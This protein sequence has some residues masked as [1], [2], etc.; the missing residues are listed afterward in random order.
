M[1]TKRILILLMMGF[2]GFVFSQQTRVHSHNDYLQKVPFWGA[3]Y[4][5]ATSI[6]ADVILKDGQLYVAHDEKSLLKERTFDNLYLS[7]IVKAAELGMLTK[8]PLQILIDIKTESKSTLAEVVK[9]I[10]KYPI[11]QNNPSLS[12][13]ISGNRPSPS[14]YK[15]YPAFIMFDHQ[16]LSPLTT[17]EWE[18][19]ALI[20]LSVKTFTKWNGKGAPIAT[21]EKQMND[22]I[23][24][25]K[26]YGKPF[27]FWAIPDAKSSWEYFA[28]AGVNFI[29]TDQPFLCRTYIEGLSRRTYTN[30][31]ISE[32]YHPAFATDGS[33]AP[34]K[35]VILLIG[36]GNGLAQISSSLLANG[37][38]LTLSQLKHIG[39]I[40]TSST[41]N[42][43]T[44]SA[45]GATAMATGKKTRNRYIGVDPEGNVLASIPEILKTK[46]Y[47]TGI[48]TT[49]EIT[50][51]TPSAF[52]AHQPERD[53]AKEIGKEFLKSTL[54]LAVAGG[55]NSFIGQNHFV[56]VRNPSEL[57][58]SKAEQVVMW[59]SEGSVPSVLNGRKSILSESVK[60]GL[61]FLQSK[62]KPFFL[63]VEGAQ[64]DSGGH[65][66]STGTII[67]EGID[68]DQ[69][70]AEAVKFADQNSGTLVII[71]A[72]HETG[73]FSL[74]HGNLK[75][76]VVEGAFETDDHSGIMVPI[77]SYGP[78]A[79]EFIGIYENH[80][81][82]H[83]I[84][85]VLA[86]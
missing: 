52:Y 79:D 59:L 66:N 21:D 42:F 47:N 19:V 50:G 38:N 62:N 5:G 69:A 17:E 11:L 67:T 30:S 6:E 3:L 49:D 73:G 60:A 35:N 56:E 83:K 10:E 7:S 76:N 36:D 2:C 53:M 34:V 65:A 54:N 78:H 63:M 72:D 37:G 32:I 46:G 64:I 22:A 77:F 15:N 41:D 40:K 85:K 43:S 28:R 81:V 20:S 86:K 25:A 13:V 8:S 33:I 70:I 12:F 74:P 16:S 39:L 68:F 57:A 4:A 71:T 84:M 23:S 14:E 58:K 27:R 48:I 18:K 80:E 31:K 26:K 24:T 1:K 45:A 61:N 9:E 29:N 44:D 75:N 51:A 55:K 82:F